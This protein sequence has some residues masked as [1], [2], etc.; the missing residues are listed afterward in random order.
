MKLPPRGAA[1][2]GFNVF[3]DHP[4][5]KMILVK[6]K[7]AFFEQIADVPACLYPSA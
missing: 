2:Y 5:G 4:C 1:K 3:C 6:Y 7:L